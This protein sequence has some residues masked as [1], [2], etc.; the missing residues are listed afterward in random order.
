MN[1]KICNVCGG[2][3]IKNKCSQCGCQVNNSNNYAENDNYNNQGTTQNFSGDNKFSKTLYT[4][5]TGDGQDNQNSY[6]QQ[7]SNVNYQYNDLNKNGKVQ[8]T[9]KFIDNAYKTKK[10][11]VY[12]TVIVII[13]V[14]LDFIIPTVSGVFEETGETTQEIVGSSGF[15]KIKDYTKDK[16]EYKYIEDSLS[17]NGSDYNETLTSGDYKVGVHIPEGSYT[18]NFD[19]NRNNSFKVID[20]KNSIK[21]DENYYA[22]AREDDI[23]K[24]ELQNLYLFEGATVRVDNTEGVVLTSNNAQTESLK[25][26]EPTAVKETLT[27]NNG[28]VSGIEFPIGT[29]DVEITKLYEGEG[30]FEY[31]GYEGSSVRIHIEEK[32]ETYKHI[33]FKKGTKVMLE[34]VS[35][36]FTTSEFNTIEEE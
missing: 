2:K 22:Y 32:K 27:I 17:E 35:V 33:E 1:K 30:V 7:N 26:L 28:N 31:G 11:T 19:N 21:I 36:V 4:I 23:E 9:L 14:L 29:Y 18:A 25:K 13:I 5:N 12:F 16:Y 10:L 34:G 6:N 20:D 3:I 24:L 15:V 8:S